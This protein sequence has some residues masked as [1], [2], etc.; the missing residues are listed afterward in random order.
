MLCNECN[1]REAL[2]HI[3]QVIGNKTTK[4]DLCQECGKRF[5]PSG[6]MASLE[7]LTCEY[8]D[9]AGIIANIVGHDKR[10]AKEAYEFVLETGHKIWEQQFKEGD[11]TATHISAAP[12]CWASSRTR[13]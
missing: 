2:I 3:T 11:F 9:T 6:A 7:G 10:Y 13:P 8:P 4:L 5:V 12:N 1:Q